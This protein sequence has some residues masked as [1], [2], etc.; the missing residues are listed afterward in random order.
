MDQA[1]YVRQQLFNYGKEFVPY[2]TQSGWLGQKALV[3]T[4]GL[5][6]GGGRILGM[7]SDF[8]HWINSL[9]RPMD[10]ILND[11][12]AEETCM[13]HPML[14]ACHQKRAYNACNQN[15]SWF[16]S[17]HPGA[18]ET[19]SRAAADRMNEVWTALPN[20]MQIIYM[21]M[22]AVLIGAY[23]LEFVWKE[24]ALGTLRPVEF[25]PVHPTQLPADRMGNYD[26]LT[27]AQPVW[28]GIM[29]LNPQNIHEGRDLMEK[30]PL[31]PG[32]LVYHQHVRMGG[33]WERPQDMQWMYY[34]R[35]EIMS[36]YKYVT[37]DNFVTQYRIKYLERHGLPTLAIYYPQ[38]NYDPTVIDQVISSWRGESTIRIPRRS[39]MDKDSLYAVE[40]LQPKSNS[41]DVFSSFSRD[42]I[43]PLI[44]AV[45]NLSSGVMMKAGKGGLAEA[46]E[47][48]QAGP[49]VATTFDVNNIGQTFETQFAPWVLWRTKRFANMPL[50]HMPTFGCLNGQA[51][52]RLNELSVME[53][54]GQAAPTSLMDWYKKAGIQPPRQLSS[55]ELEELVMPDSIN[56]RRPGGRPAAQ[57]YVKAERANKAEAPMIRQRVERELS[58]MGELNETKKFQSQ[59]QQWAANRGVSFNF[60]NGVPPKDHQEVWRELLEQGAT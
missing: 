37:M 5:K 24:D 38:T 18:D 2:D 34:G 9:S 44:E 25:Y 42:L 33:S 58:G 59:I 28:G 1:S 57:P 3:N 12:N 35:G 8:A 55:K 19:E 26:A 22:L 41:T 6:Q 11:P 49:V 21:C 7:E 31:F 36:L 56:V 32:K 43:H 4:S 53:K 29:A 51:R 50:A 48:E 14:W 20:R 54:L 16:P 47:G 13:E 52:N 23:G 60:T 45:Y 39:L 40:I 27:R 17:R 30:T 15:W 10:A 46:V